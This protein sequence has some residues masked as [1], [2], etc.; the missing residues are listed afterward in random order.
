[1]LEINNTDPVLRRL[2]LDRQNCPL[3]ACN[4]NSLVNSYSISAES[5]GRVVEESRETFTGS[6]LAQRE[7]EKTLDLRLLKQEFREATGR[8]G[9]EAVK[10]VRRSLRKQ[11]LYMLLESPDFKGRGR[12]SVI[13][14]L[15]PQTQSD[16]VLMFDDQTDACL[17]LRPTE[18][19]T[20]QKIIGQGIMFSRVWARPTQIRD[21]DIQITADDLLIFSA[22][23]LSPN[24]LGSPEVDR[25]A[26]LER[27]GTTINGEAT[28]ELPAE[29]QSML[30][31]RHLNIHERAIIGIRGERN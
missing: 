2:T 28:V 5:F 26:R 1:M 24:R 4:S 15:C 6:E 20:R 3:P 12:P 7:L 18:T 27:I 19:P 10:R 13:G 11:T 23:D 30:I 25:T 31:T 29:Q 14:L 16:D 8:G 17:V 9:L 21:A 22:Q